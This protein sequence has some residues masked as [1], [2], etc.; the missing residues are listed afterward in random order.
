L[1]WRWC[2]EEGEVKASPMARM[3][4]PAIPETP[5]PVI[6]EEDLKKLIHVCE[7]AGFHARRDMAIVR[8]AVDTGLRR[9]E[10]AGIGLEDLDLE[11]RAS[12]NV[13]RLFR[14]RRADNGNAGVSEVGDVVSREHQC[15]R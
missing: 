9:A 15:W 5:V 1:F 14:G 2:V 3:R 7:G 12:R 13:A 4:P 6:A 11:G 10:L 8:L